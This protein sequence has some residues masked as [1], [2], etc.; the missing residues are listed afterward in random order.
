MAKYGPTEAKMEKPSMTPAKMAMPKMDAAKM[1][2]SMTPAKMDSARMT[3]AKMEKPSMTPA[4]MDAGNTDYR[5]G[6]TPS[7]HD[8]ADPVQDTIDGMNGKKPVTASTFT[9]VAGTNTS[10]VDVT[11]V[12]KY[13]GN[14]GDY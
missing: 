9:E 10:Q 11:P 2:N 6:F 3:P 4:K 8:S 5:V 14:S 1:S 13:K 12:T 7:P